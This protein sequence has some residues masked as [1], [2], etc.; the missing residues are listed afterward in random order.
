MIRYVCAHNLEEAVRLLARD[1]SI[2]TP[3]ETL[4]CFETPGEAQQQLDD[5]RG[6]LK[7]AGF[8]KDARVLQVT[9]AIE[10]YETKEG[11]DAH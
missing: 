3:T 8:W 4:F 1:L 6:R 10:D 5:V 9:V 11:P 2:T 7:Y